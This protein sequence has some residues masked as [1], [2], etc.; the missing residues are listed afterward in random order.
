MRLNALLAVG[1][2]TV[3]ALAGCGGSGS[4][5]TTAAA[6]SKAEFIKKADAIC[7]KGQKRS[8]SEL[9]AFAKENNASGAKEP[10]TA[11]WAEIGTQILVP[12]LQ[13][14]LDEVRQLGSPAKDEEQIDEYLDQSEEAIEKLEEDPGEAKSPSKLLADA[15]KTIKGYG[16]KVCGGGK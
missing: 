13:R 15:H 14:Q 4:A 6:I 11:E 5:D 10:T 9:N 8:Q 2:A 3:V 1:L 12:A 7:A 16:F